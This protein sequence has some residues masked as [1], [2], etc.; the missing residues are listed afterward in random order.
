MHAAE[1]PSIDFVLPRFGAGVV[2]GAETLGRLLAHDLARAGVRVRVLTTC[3]LDHFT[4][5]NELSPGAR[6]EGGLEV[7]RFPVGPRDAG[8]WS[9]LHSE[10]D[11]GLPVSYADQ[12]RWMA[13][14]AW[15]PEMLA[16]IQ[17]AER[18]DWTIAMPYLFGTSTW[19][20]VVNPERTALIPCMHDEPHAHS[21]IVLSTLG[22][23]RGLMFNSATERDFALPLV[24]RATGTV[25]LHAV[26]GVG[27]DESP[28]PSLAAVDGF[29]R[30]RRVSR[31]YLLYAGR[32]EEAKGLP[33]LF[34]AYRAYREL[35]PDPR[36][37]ALMGSGAL[38]APEDIAPHIIDFGFVDEAEMRLA[39][40]GALVLVHPSRLESLG[41]VLLEAWLAG[42]PALVTSR[43]PV[44][45]EHCTASGGGI[46]WSDDAEFAAAIDSLGES[47]TLR[48][49][50]G[51]AGRE[52][53][54]STYRWPQVR[55]RLLS[56]LQEWE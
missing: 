26:I 54:L 10:I 20:T 15:S 39:Y 19:A 33:D 21:D 44:L 48:E 18:A 42:T 12:V 27:Y 49:G 5:E 55:G 17:S 43:G 13:N 9:R 41:M 29:L 31:G 32:R 37:L 56:S 51:N 52:Y 45:V 1:Y 22:E 36:P 46:A 35:S 34:R 16:F 24:R 28:V 30:H 7:I 50:L 8:V 53:V 3:A 14:S 2:G 38:A 6:L 25:P 4:W 23:A 11:V 47:P 40:A